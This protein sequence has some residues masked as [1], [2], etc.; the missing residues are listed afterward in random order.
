MNTSYV[1]EGRSRYHYLIIT[2]IIALSCIYNSLFSISTNV[3]ALLQEG[4]R[5]LNGEILYKEIPEINPPASIFLY[6]PAVWL[7]KIIGFKA[8]NIVLV[9]MVFLI[10]LTI[11]LSAKALYENKLINNRNQWVVF[12]VFAMCLVALD[13]FAE[14]EHIALM[15][16]LPILS[17][18]AC[19]L[20][21]KTVSKIRSALF[22]F[23]AGVAVCIKPHFAAA[24][25]IPQAYVALKSKSFSSI[26]CSEN[27][28]VAFVVLIYSA[29]FITFYDQYFDLILPKALDVYMAYRIHFMYLILVIAPL[30]L[31]FLALIALLWKLSPRGISGANTILI[32]S[33][34][35]FIV[36]YIVQGKIWSYHYYP[37]AALILL[38][39]L[40]LTA[41]KISLNKYKMDIRRQSIAC[42]IVLASMTLI[43]ILLFRPLPQDT[44]DLI[45]LIKKNYPSP[46]VIAISG[47]VGIS[48]PLIRRVNG[49]SA[50]DSGCCLITENVHNI[51]RSRP[52]APEDQRI[53]LEKW[54]S[55]DRDALIGDFIKWKPD[56]LL[57]DTRTWFVDWANW[58]KE[59]QRLAALVCQYEAVGKTPS[60]TLYFRKKNSLSQTPC[61][62][63]T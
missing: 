38:A 28:V 41:L 32:L 17:V 21:N 11:E 4:A 48:N 35:G 58:I 37:A 13:S 24:I 30:L 45:N 22:G 42:G 56:V 57:L 31:A 59:D 8:E 15:L 6:I 26:I 62:F 39:A 2:L 49:K 40:D 51:L 33:S 43:E 52:E 20:E 44:L 63:V 27:I 7:E 36:A 14:R 60:V 12:S 54:E 61:E 16:I 29:L 46:S 25:L 10:V 1:T 19:R 18:V 47:D 23:M 50:S 5:M 3:S 53:S 55:K 9:L 34:S